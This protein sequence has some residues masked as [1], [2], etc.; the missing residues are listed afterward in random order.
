MAL[1]VE[2]VSR[3]RVVWTGE[4]SY[5]RVRTV[6]GDLGISPGLIPTCALLAEDGEMLL[7]P[8]GGQDLK[9]RL[10]QGFVTVSNDKVTIA[11]K[12][13]DFTVPAT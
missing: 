6:E 5:V 4:A 2:V 10:H 12:H 11:A 9:T 8:V 3:E 13:A 1:T 7:R